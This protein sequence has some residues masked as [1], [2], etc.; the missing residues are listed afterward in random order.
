M[1]QTKIRAYT[2]LLSQSIT[3][4]EL[5]GSIAGAGLTGAAGLPLS[6]TYGSGSSTAAQGN[7]RIELNGTQYQ[8]TVTS[9][10]VITVGSGGQITLTL[11]ADLRNT[12]G[13]FSF[14]SGSQFFANSGSFGF[15]SASYINAVTASIGKLFVA[16]Y[17]P[18]TLSA[19]SLTAT[20][21]SITSASVSELVVT[22][23]NRTSLFNQFKFNEVLIYSSSATNLSRWWI[24]GS[25]PIYAGSEQLFA[26]GM[27]QDSGSTDDY[28]HTYE[29]KDGTVVSV[30]LFNYDLP[31][32]A[33]VKCNYI[34]IY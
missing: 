1:S 4:V 29:T 6:V 16:D 34:P 17:A 28:I 23:I 26:Y 10:S 3:P 5:S 19:T 30:F 25:A 14:L 2:Q 24:S 32:D 11:P 15:A 33:K 13:S 21:A 18:T 8:I 31:G 20:T 12:S 9:G 22:H 7:T 27:L